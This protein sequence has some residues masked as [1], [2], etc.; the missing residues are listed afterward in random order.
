MPQYV[1]PNLDDCE[2][3]APRQVNVDP[4]TSKVTKTLV[5]KPEE[6]TLLLEYLSVNFYQ[7]QYNKRDLY[8]WL[9]KVVF[10]DND[11]NRTVNRMELESENKETDHE[12]EV[13][14][15]DKDDIVEDLDEECSEMSE[16]H[17]KVKEPS[18][19][20]KPERIWTIEQEILLM[21][22]M[23][24]H[25]NEYIKGQY[26]CLKR[27]R[28]NHFPQFSVR[29]V[30]CKAYN[31]SNLYKLGKKSRKNKDE[32]KEQELWAKADEF[33]PLVDKIKQSIKNWTIEDDILLMNVLKDHVDEYVENRKEC[34]KRINENYFPTKSVK[35]ITDQ[36]ESLSP[37]CLK[38]KKA[39]LNMK[40]ATEKDRELWSIT[41]EVFQLIPKKRKELANKVNK[42]PPKPRK[43]ISKTLLLPK[44]LKERY[45]IS[46]DHQNLF[47]QG[48]ETANVEWPESSDSDSKSPKYDNKAEQLLFKPK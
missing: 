4:T 48:Q 16:E 10:Q 27:I 44:T 47:N 36:L 46:F 6:I 30:T 13:E 22:L 18:S 7:W 21:E 38:N 43:K 9:S 33:Y 14:E 17:V 40:D 20:K 23:K 19:I 1:H 45:R 28:E 32:K 35:K 26:E 12:D 25:I 37:R 31:L 29:N 24:Q 39:R 11:D 34:L 2:F 41:D 42:V 5:W 3:L 8:K 15:E